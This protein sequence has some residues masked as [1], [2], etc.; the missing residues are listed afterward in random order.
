MNDAHKDGS[1]RSRRL[2]S[3]KSPSRKMPDAAIMSTS[4][5]PEDHSGGKEVQEMSDESRFGPGKIM[6][7]YDEGT[8][9]VV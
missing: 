4:N 1:S 7:M 6:G 5:L 8:Q 3:S 9:S 2:F